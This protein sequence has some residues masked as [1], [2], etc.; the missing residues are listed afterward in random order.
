[1][2]NVT[3]YKALLSFLTNTQNLFFLLIEIKKEH[4]VSNDQINLI[5]T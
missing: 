3:T 4:K 2:W 1:M 5:K